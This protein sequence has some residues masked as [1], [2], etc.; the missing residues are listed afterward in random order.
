MRTSLK[1]STLAVA[2]AAASGCASFDGSAPWRVVGQQSV[3]HA[4]SATDADAQYA[5]GKYYLG[6][7]RAALALIAFTRAVERD[8]RHAD[9]YNGRATALVQL[10]DLE[11]AAEDV[12]RAIELS[13]RSAHL[14]NNQGYIR[15]QQRDFEG[16][17]ASLRQAFE[18]EPR[19]ARVLANWRLLAS[20]VSHDAVL[21]RRLEAPAA[22]RDPGLAQLAPPKPSAPVV[23]ALSGVLSGPVINLEFPSRLANGA[24]SAPSVALSGTASSSA[25]AQ[26]LPAAAQPLGEPAQARPTTTVVDLAAPR[27]DATAP[28]SGTVVTIGAA[29]DAPAAGG[30]TH[31]APEFAPARVSVVDIPAEAAHA[32]PQAPASVTV[33]AAAPQIL[34]EPVRVVDAAPRIEP[35]PSAAP[36]RSATRTLAADASVPGPV[37]RGP[38]I[39]VA[40]VTRSARIEVANGNGVRGMAASVGTQ[41]RQHRYKV[42]RVRNADHHG[43]ARTRIYFR[44]GYLPAALE[45]ARAM[46]VR[47]AIMLSNRIG[48]RSDL[49]VVVGRDFSAGEDFFAE[50][51]RPERAAWTPEALAMI[52]L[53]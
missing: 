19:N 30:T 23:E 33:N 41:L 52:H 50:G 13:P 38:V 8:P 4:G 51:G 35:A 42:V 36:E 7:D 16:A 20:R 53:R 47:P 49:Q 22:Q 31:T 25:A 2:V 5:L 43:Y 34:A 14:L 26:P 27:Q 45:L 6:Q 12:A 9:A 40:S 1:L 3:R 44:D 48:A 17:A 15:I 11:R 29:A 18:I 46:P 32:L 28:A 37:A 39:D 24:A 21:A 10:G